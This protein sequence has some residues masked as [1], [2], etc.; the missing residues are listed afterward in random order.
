[1]DR[2]RLLLAASALLSALPLR[3]LQAAQGAPKR[4]GFLSPGTRDL[5]QPNMDEFRAALKKLGYAEGRELV[6]DI[7]WSEGIT[8]RLP[9]LARELLTL[10]PA[11]LVTVTQVGAEALKAATSTVPVV[12]I[13]A[14]NPDK[15][16]F[17]ASLARPGGNMTGTA[18]RA[19]G[20][21]NK[22]AEV[23]REVL[24]TAK[25]LAVL[26]L[27]SYAGRESNQDFFQRMLPKVGFELAGI[28]RVS[29]PDELARAFGQIKAH[30]AEVA[31]A[32]PHAL[33]V[34]HAT[35]LSRLALQ[36]RVALVGP[37]RALAEGGAL[38]SYDNDVREDYRRA[39]T[40]VDRILKGA[41]PGD[42]PVEQPDRFQLVLNLRTAKALRIAI[43]P[44]VRARADEVLE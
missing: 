18:F 15:A 37:R 9:E 17:V 8:E 7:R 24:P 39:A 10:N 29:S 20:F 16:G 40:F 25:R 12:F 35:T 43:P 4:I 11:V 44:A 2:R 13:A 5:S 27:E 30:K 21:N 23:M 6:I 32:V 26:D 22:L 3:A 34:A 28:V 31:W 38:L 36:A 33:F 41:K 1:M 14:S 42:L 19:G